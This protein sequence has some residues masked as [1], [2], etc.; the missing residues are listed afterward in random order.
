MNLMQVIK[1]DGSKEDLNLEKLHKVLE[2]SCEN[3]S[4][5]SVSE[6]EVRSE[7]QIY[8]NIKTSDIHEAMIKSA[9]GLITE[10]TPNYQYVAGRLISYQLRK[11]IYNSHI[12][13]H[14]LDQYKKVRD[15][16]FY[17]NLIGEEYSDEEWDE[18]NN[19][20]D[21]NR[22][23]LLTYAAMEQYRSKYLVK[24]RVTGE[25]FE[26][27]QIAYM[28]ISM[29]LFSS[30][31]ENRIKW[32]KQLYDA[33]S[34]FDISLPTPIMS[35]VRTPQR[36]FSSC[37]LIES[38]DSLDSINA[39]SGAIVKYVANKAGVGVSGGKI[40]GFGSSIRNGDAY[41][42]GVIP[43][44]KHFN[45]AVG[46][47][48]Q[49]G[50]RK[51]SGT[52][53]Y[54]FWH[55][56]VE[57]ILVLK[58]NKGTEESRIRDLDYCIH[59]NKLFYERFLAGENIS[60]FSPSEVPGLYEAFYRNADEFKELY[61]KYEKS[62][63]RRKT[64]SASDLFSM[65]ITERKDTGRIY[66]MNVD[67]A[68]S[69]GSFLPEHAPI[70]MTNLCVEV[71][72]PTV[73]L[74]DI[75]DPLGRIALCIL[76]ALNWG[77]I[78]SPEDFKKPCELVVRLLDSLIDIQ[79][80]V[81]PAAENFT[82]DYRPLGIGIINFAYFLAKNNTNY[83]SPNLE[84]VH[85]YAEAWSYYLIRTSVDLAKEKGSCKMSKHTKYSQGILPI[86][87]Y[88]KDVDQLVKPNYKMDWNSLRKDLKLYG[89]R[90]A[91]LMACM[92]AETSALISNSTNGVEPP[93]SLVS[94]K[95][96]KDGVFAQVVPSIHKMKNKYEL[97]WDQ[98]SPEGYLKI[99]AVLQKFI[100][101]SISTNTSYNPK[102]YPDNKI[103]MSEMM[104]H[105]LMCYKYG[106]KTG[107]YLN[108]NDG[109][110]EIELEENCE[111]CKL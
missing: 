89:I 60:L 70:R 12:P 44:F 110:G 3:I 76:S 92:P 6:I 17:D 11:Q 58:N 10:E 32:V 64:I 27:P 73:P 103:P 98:E 66:Y 51:G 101:Q 79:E 82:M 50:V 56:E 15:L 57:D 63:V 13:H 22:D 39:T 88:K 106:I 81:L 18:L 54:M 37:F 71:T 100:D 7:L 93:R 48:N 62:K 104:K 36:Q 86:D 75:K 29:K 65:F 77:K 47:C 25:I 30:Y 31:K 61:E 9:A 78:K 83:S 97:L 26:T 111:S 67:H 2:W 99:M 74:N 42:T 19:H 91:T 28:L 40:R 20:I 34:T 55:Y 87:T 38:D 43:F 109:A 80:Y 35:G 95:Q 72:L 49:G 4:G 41:H 59:F 108:T 102:F 94:V 16:G 8:N 69:H 33:L 21:H 1:R 45:T 68:N 84:L 85:E 107:Y 96:S 5:V 53:N 24:N 23:D 46:S 90:N 14:I 105:V 52:L